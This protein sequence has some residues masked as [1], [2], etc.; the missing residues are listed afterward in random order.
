V[1]NPLNTS[2]RFAFPTRAE[3][4]FRL[5]GVHTANLRVARDFRLSRYRLKMALDLFNVGNLGGFQSLASNAIYNPS[6]GT[7]VSRQLPRS[8]ELSVG[9]VF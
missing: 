3:E 7:G 5:K 2:T 1:S 8:A 9:L 6:Y 4:Q